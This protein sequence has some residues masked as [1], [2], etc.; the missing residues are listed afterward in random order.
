[1]GKADKIFVHLSRRK[2][3]TG[4]GDQPQRV[5]GQLEL[6]DEAA[7]LP[8]S[9]GPFQIHGR[10]AFT[11]SNV[12]L[13]ASMASG[14]RVALK[15]LRSSLDAHDQTVLR[16]RFRREGRVLKKLRHPNIVRLVDCGE[17]RGVWYLAMEKISGKTLETLIAQRSTDLKTVHSIGVELSDAL[18]HLHQAGV[19]HRDLKPQNVLINE[20][21]RAVLADFGVAWTNTDANLTRMGDI[22]GSAAYSAP[23]IIGGAPPSVLSD[24]Y[25][26][27]CLLFE[28][29]AGP[30]PE[31]TGKQAIAPLL[32]SLS[33]DWSRFPRGD[34]WHALR[35][36]L[37][38]MLSRTP[39]RRYASA[40]DARD[41]LAGLLS[42]SEVLLETEAPQDL[43]VRKASAENR[44][45]EFEAKTEFDEG[46]ISVVG[47]RTLE[48]ELQEA[49][50]G[51]AGMRSASALRKP[52]A[53]TAIYR[54]PEDSAPIPD[55]GAYDALES[56]L[57]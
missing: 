25:A 36:I 46:V 13:D 35:P 17:I 52:S 11:E 56:T 12:V 51:P 53:H 24:Q 3:L 19:L 23:E 8:S 14:R 5:L 44:E 50:E 57:V 54:L 21:G 31:V 18:N 45:S 30:T 38:R 43:V 1:M 42:G 37:Q 16:A 28:L 10:L 41:A 49:L 7:P 55:T 26:L 39:G 9:F 15:L 48:S 29:V 20:E 6:N 4:E 34:G 2:P 40:K 33:V 32:Q 27:G 22:L 47:G